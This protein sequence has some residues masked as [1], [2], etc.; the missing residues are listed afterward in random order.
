MKNKFNKSGAYFLDSKLRGIVWDY[1]ER[2]K[3][4]ILLDELVESVQSLKEY[5]RK[6]RDP[7]VKSVNK[8]ISQWR[9]FNSNKDNVDSEED[10]VDSNIQL[11]EDKVHRNTT[12]LPLTDA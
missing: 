2:N 5:H 12:Q 4:N 7:L 3:P 11:V 9:A 10:E 1:C 8:A 6:P